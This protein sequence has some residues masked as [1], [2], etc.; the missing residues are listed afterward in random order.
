ESS[1]HKQDENITEHLLDFSLDIAGTSR[2][3][4]V[5]VYAEVFQD[6]AAVE[7]Y[8]NDA[9][10]SDCRVVLVARDH[11]RS[12]RELGASVIRVPDIKLTRVGQIKVAILLGLARGMFREGEMLVCLTGMAESH[13]LDGI[14]FMEIGEEFELFAGCDAGD[15]SEDTHPE[16]L[17][18]VLDVAVSLGT[19][20]RE[21]KPVGTIF[22]LGD[23]QDILAHSQQMVMNP[24]RGY[25]REQRNIMDAN[26]QETIK[27]FSPIDGAFIMDRDGTVETAGAYLQTEDQAVELPRGLGARHRSAAAI[28]AFTDSVSITVSETTGNITIFREGRVIME[29]EK[30]RPIG[31]TTASR[32]QFFEATREGIDVEPENG[33]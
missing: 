32:Q 6:E 9:E 20:G 26:V 8:L 21:G 29:I 24:F 5:L 1:M 14:L 10:A 25:E 30:P 2:A 27:E 33:E 22:V 13:T 19:E 16:V 31:P 12:L 28:T 23:P 18:R 7:D 15:I 17:E 4:T 11:S 3:D